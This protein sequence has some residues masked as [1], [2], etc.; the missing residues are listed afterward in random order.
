MLLYQNQGL[1][2]WFSNLSVHWNHPGVSKDIDACVLSPKDCDLIIWGM[3]L[4][5]CIYLSYLLNF[6]GEKAGSNWKEKMGD[7]NITNK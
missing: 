7:F 4:A 5:L 1:E 3:I 6:G 2:R